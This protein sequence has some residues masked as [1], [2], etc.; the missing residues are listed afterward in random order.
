MTLIYPKHNTLVPLELELQNMSTQIDLLRKRSDR[1]L[2]TVTGLPGGVSVSDAIHKSIPAE[3]STITEKDP[4]LAADIHLIEDTDDF[5]RKK[6]VQAGNL[7]GGVTVDDNG[8]IVTTGKVRIGA[9]PET[10]DDLDVDGTIF[11]KH[12]AAENDDHALEIDVD[13]AGFADIKAIDI[14]Y[15]TGAIIT[16]ENETAVLINIDDT[17]AVGGDITALEVVATEGAADR[18]NAMIVGAT[19]NPLEQLSGTFANANSISDNGSDELAALS[20]GGGGDVAV[21]TNDNEF[22]TVGSS[23]KFEELEII[24]GTGASGAGIKPTFEFSTGVGT[25]ATFSP[26]DGTNAIRNTG[27]MIWHDADIPSW[28]VGTGGEYLI[29][30]TRTRNVLGTPPIIDKVQVAATTEFAWDKNGDLSIHDLS[31]TG[32]IAVTGTVDGRDVGTDGA[33]LDTIEPGATGDQSDAEIRAAVEAATDSNVFTDAD[34]VKLDGIETAAT[35]DQT[36]AEIRAAVEAA[37]D[38]NVFTDADHTKLNG[39]EADADVTD[40]TNVNAAGATMNSDFNAKGD[41]LSASADDTPVILG[42]GTNDQ[43]LTADSTKASGLKW[44]A[45]GG[46]GGGAW[47]IVFPALSKVSG[48]S[49]PD[50]RGAADNEHWVLDFNQSTNETAVFSGMLPR[51]Y[52]GGGLTV[53]IVFAA[54]SATSGDVDWDAAFERIG[55]A[56]QDI[57]SAGFASVQSTDNT[58]V[59]GTA[60][61][62][63]EVDIAFTDGAQMD[64]IAA[65]E[66]F[67]LKITR[68]GVSDSANGDMEVLHVRLRET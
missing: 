42:V 11:L 14:D 59:N 58:T 17:Q 31:A 57:D 38:S 39:I 41:L 48:T 30:I 29:R 33:K 56:Q 49:Q 27:V 20:S 9:S 67:R 66:M 26:T 64:S 21:F 6:R 2:G 12:V 15:V 36:D 16:G 45:A 50:R 1:V 8:N 34:V 43:V 19:I 35:V 24:V 18:I 13:A 60:G 54:T 23:A 46:G 5:D 4:P 63:M 7:P 40:A 44:A 51:S 53:T 68:D 47:E 61:N 37:T 52:A 65:G 10:L 3:I 28:A 22:L 32:D 55:A 62:T 25:W